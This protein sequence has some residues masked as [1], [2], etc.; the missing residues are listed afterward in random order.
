MTEQKSVVLIVD[1]S[2]SARETL[3]EAL[4]AEGYELHQAGGGPEALER[5]AALKPDVIL[6]D[7]MMLGMDGFE[8][9]RRL[10]AAPD[11]AEA[12]VLMVT[13]LEDRG[14][15]L[16]G[17]EAGADDFISK[18][19]DRSELR[20]RVRTV[21][22]L[23]RYRKLRDEHAALE[24]SLAELSETHEATLK[25]WVE[26]L[27]LR[28]KETEGHSERVVAISVSMGEE[29]GLDDTA[30][31]HLRRGALLHDIGK[32]GVPDAVLL[33]PSKLTDEEWVLM[34]RHPGYAYEWL[35]RIPYLAE[36]AEIPSCHHEKWDGTGYPRGLRGE[37]IP[38]GARVFAFADVYDALTSERPYRA[39]WTKE[40]AL[41]QIR[42]ESG[43]HFDPSL[44]DL[45]IRVVGGCGGESEGRA[46]QERNETTGG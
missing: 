42:S 29:M 4:E 13:A 34:K 12:P 2:A 45:F 43:T 32:L 17:L 1:D 40:R 3:T 7:V 22:R 46:R 38:L 37:A 27:D 30:M 19:F 8:V 21:T 36:T 18:P 14:S 26:A 11:L 44:V 15:R 33:K 24:R 23:N 39:A 10:R 16:Q 28:D 9:C 35:V 20:A 31:A 6:L 25:G 5:A 41:A